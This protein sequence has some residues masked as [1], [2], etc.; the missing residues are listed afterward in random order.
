ML[1]AWGEPRD[2]ATD[3]PVAVWRGGLEVTLRRAPDGR[4]VVFT[5]VS[6]AWRTRAGV[7]PGSTEALLRARYGDRLER[8]RDRRGLL[9]VEHHYMLRAHGRALGFV[10]RPG[11]VLWITTGAAGPVR[12]GLAF[13]GPV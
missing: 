10:M 1:R 3:V 7:R 8:V 6:P 13:A 9:G 11:R 2:P 4:A 12:A 5:V